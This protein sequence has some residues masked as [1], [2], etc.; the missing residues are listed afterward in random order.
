M[1]EPVA[2]VN[3][4]NSIIQQIHLVPAQGVYSSI[5]ILL[6]MYLCFHPEKYGSVNECR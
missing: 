5:R 1:N 6:E 4:N 3:S 2:G